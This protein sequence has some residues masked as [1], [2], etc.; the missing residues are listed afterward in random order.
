MSREPDEPVGAVSSR[1][2][3]LIGLLV[4]AASTTLHAQSGTGLRIAEQSLRGLRLYGYW[5]SL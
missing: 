5:S 1:S 4:V 3:R 2:H